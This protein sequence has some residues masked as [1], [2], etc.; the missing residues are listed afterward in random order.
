MCGPTYQCC[1][2]F[3]IE[4]GVRV[5]AILCQLPEMAAFGYEL[6]MTLE[7][8]GSFRIQSGGENASP[9]IYKIVGLSFV[10]V[11]ASLTNVLLFIGVLKEKR[12]WIL[13]WLLFN[14]LAIVVIGFSI[15]L[16]IIWFLFISPVPILTLLAF[17][18]LMVSFT[19]LVFWVHVNGYFIKLGI[20]EIK[21]AHN[22]SMDIPL[23]T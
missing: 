13:P 18:P 17:I 4:G 1:F 8:N 12:W 3:P 11:V 7:N 20:D 23:S 22:D 2:C 15:P 14:M 16:L 9:M 5:I 10:F 21:R 19:L 6:W